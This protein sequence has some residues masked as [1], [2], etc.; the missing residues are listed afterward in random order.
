MLG[1]EFRSKYT[2]LKRLTQRGIRSYQAVDPDGRSVMV[3]VLAVPP[4]KAQKF[5]DLLEDLSHQ[6]KRRIL[7]LLEVEG[8]PVLVTEVLDDFETL[9]GWLDSRTKVAA[10]ES[11]P[12]EP[13]EFTRLFQAVR[14]EQPPSAP[15]PVLSA[16]VIAEAEPADAPQG[17]P[18]LSEPAAAPSVEPEPAVS[19]PGE[20]TRLFG[21]QQK[22]AEE[23]ER[24][25]AE[26]PAVE[27]EVVREA[28]GEVARDP[29]RAE[30]EAE[31][32]AAPEERE[33]GE[34][35]R[36][37]GVK[38][39]LGKPEAAAEEPKRKKPLIHWREGG[40][41]EGEPEV[42]PVVRW[43]KRGPPEAAPPVERAEPPTEQDIETT[44]GEFTKLFRQSAPQTP[45]F[46]EDVA[47]RGKRSGSPLDRSTGEYLRAL[48]A[49]IPV[50]EEVPAPGG[51]ASIEPP[52]VVP[53]VEA[54]ASRAPAPADDGP[55]EFTRLVAGDAAR[56]DTPAPSAAPE[57]DEGPVTSGGAPSLRVL[58]IGLS[59]I[60][61]TI[62]VLIILFAVL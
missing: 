48:D 15:E 60:V 38:A 34:F 54:P 41:T 55:S 49:S 47:R 53:P 11:G 28:P 26:P 33:P 50:R 29:G 23:P 4:A 27:P 9:P 2:L 7:D 37:F 19:P 44:G 61:L 57:Y 18:E 12:S 58:V 5:L 62:V 21:P 46:Q 32:E 8:A 24:P 31:A 6:D 56:P 59:A 14:E 36:L 1:D 39:A 16:E 51:P 22:V 52:S 17:E 45:P 30:A 42:K 3:H 10:E 13:G 20:F 40:P 35:T 25:A 43:K